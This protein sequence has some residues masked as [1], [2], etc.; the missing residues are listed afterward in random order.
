MD[1]FYDTRDLTLEQ[2]L[3]NNA[4]YVVIDRKFYMRDGKKHFEIGFCTMTNIEYFLFIHVEDE[5]AYPI[6]EKYGLQPM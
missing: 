2:K 5:K 6:L 3:T 1:I 4:H